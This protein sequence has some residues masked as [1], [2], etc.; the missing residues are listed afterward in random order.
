[1]FLSP[2]LTGVLICQPFPVTVVVGHNFFL[3]FLLNEF[4]NRPYLWQSILRQFFAQA[5]KS[6]APKNVDDIFK[7]Q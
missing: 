7:R 3:L 2:A 1:M 6:R 5:G 4:L